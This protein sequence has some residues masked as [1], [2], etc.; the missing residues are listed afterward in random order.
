M[1]LA[2][3]LHS[4]SALST[5]ENMLQ[6]LVPSGAET[7]L[8]SKWKSTRAD[9]KSCCSLSRDGDA[10][11]FWTCYPFIHSLPLF[12]CK[13]PVRPI[14]P[15]TS[16]H[17]TVACFAHLAPGTLSCGLFGRSCWGSMCLFTQSPAIL[18]HRSPPPSIGSSPSV[19]TLPGL[20]K[21]GLCLCRENPPPLH[22]IL[23]RH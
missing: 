2:F 12:L 13:E 16:L 10:M 9:N 5:H 4:V 23:D 3:S 22:Q 18:L 15:G 17:Y 7:L 19:S 11:S 6:F 1:G 20:P 21:Q 8:D 14:R